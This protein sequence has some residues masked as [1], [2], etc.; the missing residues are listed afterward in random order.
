[1]VLVRITLLRW[2]S[3]DIRPPPSVRQ[4]ITSNSVVFP[5][6]VQ[7]NTDQQLPYTELIPVLVLL[8]PFVPAYWFSVQNKPFIVKSS[9]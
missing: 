8:R 2:T 4:A 6:P 3:P 9:D 1:M 5:L 7:Q